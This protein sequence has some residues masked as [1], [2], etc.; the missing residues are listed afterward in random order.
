MKLAMVV[1]LGPGHIVSDGDSS[2][3]KKEGAQPPFSAHVYCGQMAGWV[4][5]P[6]GIEVGLGPGDIVLDGDPAPPKRA[7]PPIFG[8]C[9]TVAKWLDASG[10]TWYGGR[11][12]HR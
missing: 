3:P 5:L 6:L 10:G 12:W 11:P 7:Q 9:S 8:S 4:K 1:G 2:L